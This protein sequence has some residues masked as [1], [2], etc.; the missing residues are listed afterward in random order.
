MLRAG[1]IGVGYLGQHHARI[2]SELQGVKLAAVVDPDGQR[3]S[4]IAR[5]YGCAAFTDYRDALDAVDAFSIVTPTTLHYDVALGCILAGKNVLIEKPITATIEEADALI[6]AA[7]KAGVMVQVGHLERFNPAVAALYP[8]IGE[9]RFFE[10]SRLSPFLG[11]GIDVDIPL[12]LMIHDLDIIL[13][14]ISHAAQKKTID[15]IPSLPVE[16]RATGFNVMTETIDMAKAWLEFDGGIQALVSASRH[17]QIK[18]RTLKIYQEDSYLFVDYQ[19]M[20]LARFSRQGGAVV[21]EALPVEKKE[22][23]KEE[24]EDFARC[25]GSGTKPRVCALQGRNALKLAL[26]IGET[27]KMQNRKFRE[28]P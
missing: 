23:L 8:L 20:E 26:Q 7:D 22:P 25:I 11:R 13:S 1:V 28:R 6:A 17:S 9:P 15:G 27:I 19:N 24:L 10:A 12:D 4:E 16:V 5:K 14:L 21:R 3:A 2:F 18:A